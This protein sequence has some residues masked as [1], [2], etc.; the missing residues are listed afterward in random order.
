MSS[1]N[2]ATTAPLYTDIYLSGLTISLW[3]ALYVI[4]LIYFA[5]ATFEHYNS[6]KCL[7]N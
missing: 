2:T 1:H 5:Q 3:K 6:G 4:N 7:S